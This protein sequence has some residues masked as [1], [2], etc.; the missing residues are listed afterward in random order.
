MDRMDGWLFERSFLFFKLLSRE[1][2]LLGITYYRLR[3]IEGRMHASI[4]KLTSYGARVLKKLD[5]LKTILFRE[6]EFGSE[7]R[8]FSGS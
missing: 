6:T 7:G 8:H 4:K 1:A 3:R 5:K 2:S